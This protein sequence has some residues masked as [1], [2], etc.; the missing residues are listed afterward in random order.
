LLKD[1]SIMLLIWPCNTFQLLFPFTTLKYWVCKKTKFDVLLK[2]DTLKMLCVHNFNYCKSD[3]CCSSSLFYVSK[4]NDV[5]INS[6]NCQGDTMVEF[7]LPHFHLKTRNVSMSGR[8]KN[9]E[10]TPT[11]P[12]NR[13][14]HFLSLHCNKSTVD[15]QIMLLIKNE[16]REEVQH[17]DTPK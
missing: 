8:T 1:N 12:T 16:I 11:D 15:L 13:T 10:P 7:S 4:K 9:M 14:S 17:F 2:D 5:F 6:T 3:V